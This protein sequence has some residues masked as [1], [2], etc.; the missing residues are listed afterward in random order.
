MRKILKGFLYAFKGICY[1]F[2]TQINFKIHTLA[3]TTVIFAGMIVGLS[4]PEWIGIIIVMGIVLIAELINTSIEVLVDLVSPGFNKQAG[5]VKD[6]SAAAVL[7]AACL[8]VIV[9]LLIFVPK[10]ISYA[11]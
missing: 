9:G 3:I 2:R 5:T 11:S 4:I 8:A 7:L 6:L 1:A 10:L